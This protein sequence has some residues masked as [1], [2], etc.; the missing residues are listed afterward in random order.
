[1]WGM[2][3]VCPAKEAFKDLSWPASFCPRLML[4]DIQ[5]SFQRNAGGAL[6]FLKKK[7]RTNKI[8][9][10]GSLLP[11]TPIEPKISVVVEDSG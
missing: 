5:S 7:E 9:F 3:D 2:G 10:I 8:L 4:S 1:M 6:W 11:A